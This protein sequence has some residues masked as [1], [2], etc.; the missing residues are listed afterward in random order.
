MYTNTYYTEIH[1]HDEDEI[2][3]FLEWNGKAECNGRKRDMNSST[4]LIASSYSGSSW[5]GLMT[6]VTIRFSCSLSLPF[7]QKLHLSFHVNSF[8]VKNVRCTVKWEYAN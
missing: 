4:G 2:L 6:L 1:D 3:Y 5:F 7:K 8:T